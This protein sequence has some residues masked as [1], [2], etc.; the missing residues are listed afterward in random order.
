MFNSEG[1]MKDH[2]I[3]IRIYGEISPQHESDFLLIKGVLGCKNN[4]EAFEAMIDKLAP[5]LRKQFTQSGNR[6]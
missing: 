5:Q 1:I 6:G 3:K 4:G 2:K